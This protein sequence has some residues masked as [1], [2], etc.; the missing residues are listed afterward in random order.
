MKLHYY[1]DTASLYIELIDEPGTNSREIVSGLLADL[2][3]HERVVGLDIDC[4]IHRVDVSEVEAVGW[5]LQK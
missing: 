2:N 1:P 4:A 5:P 3:D